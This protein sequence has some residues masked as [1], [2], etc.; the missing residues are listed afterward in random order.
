VRPA[1]KD[2]ASV[3][4]S[5]GSKSSLQVPAARFDSLDLMDLRPPLDDGAVADSQRLTSAPETSTGADNRRRQFRTASN[6]GWTL[7]EASKNARRLEAA[8]IC[9][10]PTGLAISAVSHEDS[11]KVEIMTDGPLDVTASPVRPAHKSQGKTGQARIPAVY[12]SDCVPVAEL[13]LGNR[14]GG[15]HATANPANNRA[16]LAAV[17]VA[18]VLK[19][20]QAWTGG[21]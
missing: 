5:F 1:I 4:R 21:L 19:S 17:W 6:Q 7:E 14:R 3:T 20:P 10:W 12:A 18:S 11:W 2:L 15:Y 13:Y 9:E 8:I 16:G